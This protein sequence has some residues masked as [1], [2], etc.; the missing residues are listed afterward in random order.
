MTHACPLV[1]IVRTLSLAFSLSCA[2][3]DGRMVAGSADGA[4]TI[5]G[6]D[7]RDSANLS[8]AARQAADATRS[9]CA[10]T[11]LDSSV[12]SA[13]ASSAL[14]D[15]VLER[16]SVCDC[17]YG[18]SVSIAVANRGGEDAVTPFFVDVL[19]TP[20]DDGSAALARFEF[21]EGVPAGDRISASQ[22]IDLGRDQF[23][24]FSIVVD[25]PDS[26]ME[27][28]EANNLVVAHNEIHVCF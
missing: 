1:D 22:D 7:G 18:C 25:R 11:V 14:P 13:A 15:L 9:A 28:N 26:V 3:G 23:G 27:A 19:P 24:G 16:Y 21:S 4:A 10:P 17:C 12:D 2:A 6:A 20:L 8:S 5:E